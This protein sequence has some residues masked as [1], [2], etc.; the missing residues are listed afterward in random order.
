[1]ARIQNEYVVKYEDV[2]LSPFTEPSSGEKMHH[3]CI[4]MEYCEGY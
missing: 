3:L 4:V 2:F 1:M